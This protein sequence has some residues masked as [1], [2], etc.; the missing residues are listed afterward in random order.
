MSY[1]TRITVIGKKEPRR[2]SPSKMVNMISEL[3]SLPPAG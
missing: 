1:G 3:K 2:M